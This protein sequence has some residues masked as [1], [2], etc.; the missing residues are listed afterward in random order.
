M[1]GLDFSNILQN[2][3]R[4]DF[5]KRYDDV[6][7]CLS[8]EQ[9]D[10]VSKQKNVIQ[11]KNLMYQEF[12]DYLFEINKD[13]FVSV[14]DGVHKNIVNKYINEI[15]NAADS[16]VSRTEQ[17]EKENE[18]LKAQIK[19]VLEEC[20]NAKPVAANG[21]GRVREDNSK[22]AFRQNGNSRLNS[23]DSE[24]VKN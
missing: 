7:N 20:G 8:S 10:F 22:K 4:T 1:N 14:S 24:G 16:Y 18:E 17:L 6:I 9:R 3:F 2:N 12:I 19:K 11:A 15:K 13:A 23:D 21:S 5:W